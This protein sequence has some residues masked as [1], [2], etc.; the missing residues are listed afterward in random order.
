MLLNI[1]IILLTF[2][3]TSIMVAA[4]FAIVRVRKSALINRQNERK[5]KGLP[6]SKKINN[7]IKIVSHLNDYLS[8]TQIG[9][10]ISG[11]ILGW[12]GER[13][14]SLIF[15]DLGIQVAVASIFSIAVLTYLEVVLTELIPK[16]IAI[17]F[18]EKVLLFVTTP[19]I[20]FHFSFLPFIK[21][22]NGSTNV[23]MKLLHL[24]NVQEEDV[25]SKSEI[26]QI[27]QSSQSQTDLS[28][29]DIQFMQKAFKF[30]QKTL[31]DIMIPRTKIIYVDL[32]QNVQDVL[33]FMIEKDVTR[34]LVTNDHDKDD[35]IGYIYLNDLLKITDKNAAMLSSIIKEVPRLQG[36]SSLNEAHALM[37]QKRVPLIVINDEY[38]GVDGLVTDKDISEEL[39]GELRDEKIDIDESLIKQVDENTFIIKGDT[40]LSEFFN[41]FDLEN[42][43]NDSNITTI[44]RYIDVKNNHSQTKVG[45]KITINNFTIEVLKTEDAFVSELKLSRTN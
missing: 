12:L 40:P 13:T 45:D 38:G 1:I 44:G 6:P 41:Y 33:N 16:N 17:G 29:P 18:S 36:S 19:L 11:I 35:V 22:L 34:V 26:L 42:N 25:F 30:S 39:F 24:P 21:V 27:A 32:S 23:I 4:E 8:T 15:E 9:I 10:T 5:H 3:F 20:I 43:I 37:N 2:V 28:E 7:A 31:K 14:F